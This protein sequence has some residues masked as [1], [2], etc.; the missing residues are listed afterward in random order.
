MSD[1]LEVIQDGKISKRINEA[2]TSFEVSFATPLEPNDL[3]TGEV[4]EFYIY[5]N[6]HDD[7]FVAV[8]GIVEN[9]KRDNKDD[10]RIY[11]ISGRDRGRLLV[12]QPFDFPCAA[13]SAQHYT[14]EKLLELILKDTGITIGRG[15]TPLSERVVLNTSENSDRRFCNTWNTKEEAIN[16]LFS[17]YSRLAGAKQFRWYVNYAGYFRWFETSS[18]RAGKTYIFRDDDRILSFDIEE[19]A[20]NIVNDISGT[21]G[22]EEN[23]RSIH[24]TNNKSIA[25]YGRCVGQDINEQN[26]TDE[27][28]RAALQK[29][30]DM[31][32]WPI[33]TVK[34][35]LA[36]VHNYEP[37]TQVMFPD[38]KYYKDLVFTVV[39]FTISVTRAE[40]KTTLNL[41]T[42][43]SSISVAN[44][45]DVVQTTAK[46]EVNEAKSRVGVVVS[47]PNKN[48]DR[49]L[50]WVPSKSGGSIINARN[51]GGDWD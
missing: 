11:S 43:E 2:S 40:P 29:E 7:S 30:L 35:E 20:T 46:H 37:G 26:Y 27:Q 5:D 24:L 31:K 39:D 16:Q 4:F 45:F 25:K 8:T 44:E 34:L 51:P 28:L 14:V 1:D 49:C 47:I 50:V 19:D 10:N 12:T 9:I 38:Y 48:D 23:Q 17:Q 22:D 42:D 15:Q 33:Y 6:T 21:Y 18:E 3:R 36:G 32:A 41:T 13:E